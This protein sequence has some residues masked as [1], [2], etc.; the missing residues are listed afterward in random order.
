VGLP[1]SNSHTLIGSII[2]VGVADSMMSP[3]H[4]TATEMSQSF[5]LLTWQRQTEKA[6]NASIEFE[7]ILR[8]KWTQNLRTN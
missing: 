2:G 8:I 5:P 4:V 1:A 3:D 7:R 6:R